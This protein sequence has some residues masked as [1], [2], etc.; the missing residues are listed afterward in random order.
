ML[1]VYTYCMCYDVMSLSK[2]ELTGPLYPRNDHA[3]S[4][5]TYIHIV[6]IDYIAVVLQTVEMFISEIQWKAHVQVLARCTVTC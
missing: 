1:T 5:N 2:G 4:F 6:C 3:V